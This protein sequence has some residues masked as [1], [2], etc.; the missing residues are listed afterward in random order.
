MLC[1]ALPST[2]TQVRVLLEDAALLQVTEKTPGVARSGKLSSNASPGYYSRSL[3]FSGGA[4][5]L[6]V[7][8][9]LLVWSPILA[10]SLALVPSL[11]L[12]SNIFK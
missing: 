8:G 2:S 9:L 10:H 5:E 11:Y 3:G 4:E 7:C 6:K 1:V 12:I